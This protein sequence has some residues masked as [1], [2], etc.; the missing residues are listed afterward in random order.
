[1]NPEAQLA[2]AALDILHGARAL[3]AREA[4]RELR[5]FLNSISTPI[6]NSARL[7]NA[8]DAL[9]TLIS[10]LETGNA[11]TND[12]WGYA[13]QAMESLANEIRSFSE[14]NSA[15]ARPSGIGSKVKSNVRAFFPARL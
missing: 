12:D 8:S 11:A 9:K 5:D 7:A 13:I 14:R 3:P 10:K 1:M 15:I 4:A 2:T 6:P